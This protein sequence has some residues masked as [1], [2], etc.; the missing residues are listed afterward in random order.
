MNN[1]QASDLKMFLDSRG[2]GY[3]KQKVMY[4]IPMFVLTDSFIVK[5]DNSE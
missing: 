5:F 1:N 3:F 2:K 4:F